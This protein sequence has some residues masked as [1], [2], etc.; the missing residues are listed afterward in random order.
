[1]RKYRALSAV[2]ISLGTRHYKRVLR[3]RLCAVAVFLGF[4]AAACSNT[5]HARAEV[6]ICQAYRAFSKEGPERTP[7]DPALE[8]MTRAGK[9]NDPRFAVIQHDAQLSRLSPSDVQYLYAHCGNLG[10]ALDQSVVALP[11][12]TGV[13]R[14]QV[15]AYL[16]HPDIAQ[17]L[18]G[19]VIDDESQGPVVVLYV[20]TAW[21]RTQRAQTVNVVERSGLVGA[22][23]SALPTSTT[24]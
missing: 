16:A 19:V 7:P 8:S 2:A 18:A 12:K 4:V 6:R 13:T 17:A 15:D 3:T 5:S 14:E 23:Q 10:V 1:M 11:F 9:P 20:P 22:Q 21:S 24:P